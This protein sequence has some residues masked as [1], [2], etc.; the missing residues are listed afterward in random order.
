MHMP[1]TLRVQGF[2]LRSCT[3]RSRPLCTL[4]LPAELLHTSAADQ[5]RCWKADLR[6]SACRCKG[7][8]S[9]DPS[10]SVRGE[11]RSTWR[12]EASS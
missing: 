6:A 5:A 2:W 7:Q 4:Q 1:R 12:P 3:P 10:Q 11:R 8:G 9:L